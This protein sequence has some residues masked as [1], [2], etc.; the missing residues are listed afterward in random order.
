[1]SSAIFPKTMAWDTFDA[2]TPSLHFADN[3]ADRAG[4]DSMWKLCPVM[5]VLNE[6]FRIVFIQTRPWPSRRVCGPS[7]GA[8][9]PL[10]KIKIPLAINYRPNT[11][12]KFKFIFRFN[13]L[14][15]IY[16]PVVEM[17]NNK[18]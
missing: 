10:P 15:R 13:R 12:E 1:M 8:I 2:L 4:D 11:L 9:I 7:R 18:E 6:T 17:Q 5:D 16:N 3:K 14:N